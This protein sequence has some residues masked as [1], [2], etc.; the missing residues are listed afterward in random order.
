MLVHEYAHELL[1]LAERHRDGAGGLIGSEV[2]RETEADA[3]TFL[4]LG[5]IGL[6]SDCPSY[7][8]WR[9]G[10][11]NVILRS[12]RRIL[13]AAKAIGTAIDGSRPRGSIPHMPGR[14]RCLPRP[15]G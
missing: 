12:L 14:R 11:G 5:M 8:A 10:T 15:S 9:G 3:T 6:A 2:L 1:H 4:V 7:I 13:A